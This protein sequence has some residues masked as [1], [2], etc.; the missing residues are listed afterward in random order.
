MPEKVCRYVVEIR[1]REEDG[2]LVSRHYP[3]KP[4]DEETL[5]SWPS[6]GQ[7]QLSHALFVEALR[8]EAYTTMIS[9]MSKGVHPNDLDAG[10]LRAN[11]Q[12]H[13]AE[14]VGKFA[15]SAVDEALKMLADSGS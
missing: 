2:A 3:Q 13:L 5:R 1:R 11:V 12:A 9:R 15:A 6:A 10:E 4:S 8:R 14:M 7:A